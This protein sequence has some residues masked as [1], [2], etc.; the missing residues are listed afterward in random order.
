MGAARDAVT[1]YEAARRAVDERARSFMAGR[2][3]GGGCKGVYE[4]ELGEGVLPERE[5]GGD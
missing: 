4:G 2:V 1:A 5:N 3:R